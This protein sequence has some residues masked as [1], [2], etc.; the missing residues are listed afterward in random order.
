MPDKTFREKVQKFVA[1]RELPLEIF[2]ELH[3]RGRYV[4]RQVVEEEEVT[5]NRQFATSRFVGLGKIAVG[6]VNTTTGLLKNDRYHD[7]GMSRYFSA[8]DTT[9]EP[10]LPSYPGGLVAV[11][12]LIWA[13]DATMDKLSTPFEQIDPRLEEE[14]R[15]L[16]P[17][18]VADLRSLAKRDHIAVGMPGARRTSQ[19]ATLSVLREMY[20]F[21]EANDIEYL[22][23]GLEPEAWPDYY[24]RFR[25]G[26][27]LM[28]AEGLSMQ[29]P[30]IQGDQVGIRMPIKESYQRYKEATL[31]GPLSMRALRLMMMEYYAHKVPSYQAKGGARLTPADILLILS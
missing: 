27:E 28:H 11:G 3:G 25:G 20:A 14:M 17:G 9:I 6:A 12:K 7:L 21:A 8:F 18:K 10:E 1:Q 30:G 13:P 5:H 29:F 15:L 26:V 22:A 24:L 2:R 23:A 31:V 4:T 16:G 19:V